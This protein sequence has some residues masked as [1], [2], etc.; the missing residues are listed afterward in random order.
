MKIRRKR[1]KTTINWKEIIVQLVVEFIS[2]MLSLL[3]S[4]LF[5]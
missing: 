4:K 3:I 2:I 1:K 5:K